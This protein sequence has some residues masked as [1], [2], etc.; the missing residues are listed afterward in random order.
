MAHI[1]LLNRGPSVPHTTEPP[2]PCT[3]CPELNFGATVECDGLYVYI[4]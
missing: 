2:S 1:R 3:C 4:P